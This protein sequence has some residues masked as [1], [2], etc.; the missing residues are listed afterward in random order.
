MIIMW[1]T[2]MFIYVYGVA[3]LKRKKQQEEFDIVKKQ[4]IDNIKNDNILLNYIYILRSNYAV[5]R[6]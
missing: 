1:A 2:L 6:S 5:Y 3:E 4:L